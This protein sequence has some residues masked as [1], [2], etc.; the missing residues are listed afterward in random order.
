MME[1]SI[2]HHPSLPQVYQQQ[3]YLM[4][5][6]LNLHLDLQVYICFRNLLIKCCLYLKVSNSANFWNQISNLLWNNLNSKIFQEHLYIRIFQTRINEEKTHLSLKLQL[7]KNKSEAKYLEVIQD[8]KFIF[9]KLWECSHLG[10]REI[11][12]QSV[13]SEII[14][15]LLWKYK[16]LKNWE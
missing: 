1:K 13:R 11:S 14:E 5:T 4:Q 2:F 8:R 12:V 3:Q 15:R 9:R 10:F 16:V 6:E 7:P